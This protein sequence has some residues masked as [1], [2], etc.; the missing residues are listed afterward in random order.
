MLKRTLVVAPVF[1]TI[2]VLAAGA[3]AAPDPQAIDVGG[4]KLI[5]LLTVVTKHDDNIF[6]QPNGEESD[7]ITT[8]KPSVQWLQQKDTT[9]LALTYTGDYGKYWDSSDD[10][11]DDHTISFDAVMAASDMVRLD[12]GA[13]YGWQHDNR[14]EGSSEG[15]NALSRGEPDEYE[16]SNINVAVDLGRDSAMFG[17]RL[18]GSRDD[19]EYQN[20]RNET[21][22]RDRD[23]TSLA[24]R[25]YGKLSGGKTKLFAQV[26]QKDI[27]YDSNPLLGGKL[28]SEEQGYSVGMEWEITGR[29]SGEV[30]VGRVD[31]EFDSA[32]RRDGSINIVE[33]QVTWAPRTY[34][35]FILGVSRAPRETNGTG[36]FIEAQDVSLT[37]LHGWSDQLSSMVTI[38]D[39]TDDYSG[40]PRSD[41]RQY[42]SVSLDYDWRRWMTVGASYTYQ[43]R[44][45]N[46]ALFEYDKSVFAVKVDLS[47]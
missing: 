6:S 21:I 5:P 23:E 35:Q 14:G 29:T 40:N 25:F 9:A 13:S 18:T 12:A 28:D 22:F 16:I 2:G 37:W 38:S 33:A 32:A 36:N 4:G 11:Y 31:K 39:G 7:T 20:N 3:Q 24:A 15:I 34:S 47:L 41:D 10:N 8:L 42:Y 30:R 45:S 26:S 17:V 46:N 19:I 27:S 43:E 44:D 1:L